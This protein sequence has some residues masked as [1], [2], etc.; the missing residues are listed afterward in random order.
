MTTKAQGL[1]AS[2]PRVII[3]GIRQFGLASDGSD[4]RDLEAALVRLSSPTGAGR[5]AGVQKEHF[6]R[7][8][9][10]DVAH[11]PD[12]YSAPL[13][14]RTT[15]EMMRDR[16]ALRA[17]QAPALEDS[18]KLAVKMANLKLGPRWGRPTPMAHPH[19]TAAERDLI[20]RALSTATASPAEADVKKMREAL[21][22]ISK[23]RRVVVAQGDG[24]EIM[25]T[26]AAIAFG[27]LSALAA[28]PISEERAK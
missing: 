14:H 28:S 3:A 19:L 10:G 15:R 27:T 6:S 2:D 12:G 23:F 24:I 7:L 22:Q 17:Q 16:D 26:E 20:V 1:S 8:S 4:L 18:V 25:T 11:I 5:E 21:E 13:D 9:G